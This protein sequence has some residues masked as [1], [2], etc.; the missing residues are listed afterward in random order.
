[1]HTGEFLWE[2]PNGETPRHI[3]EHPR[4]QG[5]HIPPTGQMVHGVTMP[6]RTLL[7]TA[8][9]GDP[10]LYALDKRTGTRLGTVRLPAPGQYGMMGYL[11]EGRQYVV[12]QIASGTLPGSLVVLRLPASS[13]PRGLVAVPGRAGTDA[14]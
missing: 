8:P 6:T 14:P 7:L 11:H 13:R 2:T 12:V 9:G 4:L 5:L 10:V 1:M 3:R